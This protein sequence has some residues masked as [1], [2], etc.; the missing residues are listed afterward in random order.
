MNFLNQPI[1]AS[2][3][4]LPQ[5]GVWF[6]QVLAFLVLIQ[7]S[8]GAVFLHC[9]AT[10]VWFDF[11]GNGYIRKLMAFSQLYS[12]N[13]AAAKSQSRYSPDGKLLDS[14]TFTTFL[15]HPPL[16]YMNIHNSTGIKDE[17]DD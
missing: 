10:D 11:V 14:I 17:K 3:E 7:Q 6:G 1:T 12:K 16:F 13:K 2:D 4:I 9:Q 15:F 8:C 5:R